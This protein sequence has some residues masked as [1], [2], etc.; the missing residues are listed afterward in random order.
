MKHDRR[1]TDRVAKAAVVAAAADLAAAVVVAAA[2]DARAAAA[3]A[4]VGDVSPTLLQALL[5][6]S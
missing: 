5:L 2:V 4:A 1:P 6:A 3:V